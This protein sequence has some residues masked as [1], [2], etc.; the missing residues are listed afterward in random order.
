MHY[1]LLSLCL[2][3]V[4]ALCLQWPRCPRL[5]FL[6]YRTGMVI[7]NVIWFVYSF[8]ELWPVYNLFLFLTNWTYFFLN[9]Y[10]ILFCA[11]CWIDFVQDWKFARATNASEQEAYAAEQ[12]ECVQ[13]DPKDVEAGHMIE[14]SDHVTGKSDHMTQ[15]CDHMMCTNESQ[16]MLPTQDKTVK[17]H[18]KLAEKDHTKPTEKD[19]EEVFIKK[20]ACSM[21]RQRR[22]SLKSISLLNSILWVLFEFVFNAYVIITLCYWFFIY[23]NHWIPL[24]IDLNIHLINTVILFIDLFICRFPVRLLHVVY[25]QTYGFIYCIF[26][27]VYWAIDPEHNVIYP[28][29]LDWNEPVRPIIVNLLLFF[30]VTPSVQIFM[31]ALHQIKMFTYNKIYL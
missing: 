23:P 3:N 7:Y 24:A 12:A 1:V 29:L 17:P 22:S 14:K 28:G 10:L 19:Q 15:K 26:S 8:R 21:Q 9:V 31:F 16:G 13:Y 11:L 25:C 5:V 4:S 18:D 30:V 27:V 20:R 6:T 2:A